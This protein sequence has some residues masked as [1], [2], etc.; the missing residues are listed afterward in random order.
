MKS[1]FELYNS[2]DVKK[3]E[4][5]KESQKKKF[6]KKVSFLDH[7]QCINFFRIIIEH[8]YIVNE[9]DVHKLPYGIKEHDGWTEF[10]LENLPGVLQVKLYKFLEQC[11]N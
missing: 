3:G 1:R 6:I 7:E 11:K 2:L 8:N 4:I 9:V 10:D 5:L